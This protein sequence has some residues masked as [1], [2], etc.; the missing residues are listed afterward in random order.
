MCK[1][2]WNYRR[3]YVVPYWLLFFFFFFT[4]P[5][6]PPANVMAYFLNCLGDVFLFLALYWVGLYLLLCNLVGHTF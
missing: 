5:G 3:E 1:G 4:L 2:Q 6:Y